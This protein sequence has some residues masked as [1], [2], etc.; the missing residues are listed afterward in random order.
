M[1]QEPEVVELQESELE[2]L[3]DRAKAALAEEDFAKFGKILSAY[4]YLLQLIENKNY[5]LARLKSIIFGSKSEKTKDVFKKT[6]IGDAPFSLDQ[7]DEAQS[8]EKPKGHGRNGAKAY[9]NAEKVKVEHPSLKPKDPCP[10]CGKGKLYPDTPGSLVRITGQAPLKATEYK[11]DKLR[12]NG[13]GKLFQAPL[14]AGV[15]YTKY[16]ATAGSM[17][18]V[19][20]YGS[21]M[22]F[23]R[24]AVLE[25]N[26]GVPLPA[27]TQWEIVDESA[28]LARPAYVELIRQA[29]QGKVLHNDDTNMKILALIKA[30]KS[31]DQGSHKRKGC[32][33]T[34]IVSLHEDHTIA[35]FFTGPNH[36]GEN[37][38]KVLKER[39]A[40]LKPPIQMCDALSRNPS[41]EFETILANCVSHSRR[42][43]VEVAESFPEECK[44]LLDT[45]KEVYLN[46]TT[47]K[48]E[49]MSDDERLA[50]H[51]TN[52]QSHMDEIENWGKKL[53]DQKKIEPNSG[54]GQALTYML[55]HWQELTLFLRYPGAPLDNNI[56]ERS[57][58]KA[59]LHRKNSMFYK[60]QKGADVG[61]LFMSLI[62]TAELAKA[63]PFDYI[64]ALLQNPKQVRENPAD[65]MP[66]NYQEALARITPPIVD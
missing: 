64:T 25:Q 62:H 65:W 34:G 57:L 58:K 60:T 28:D 2:G 14:P 35:L 6:A 15:P 30:R 53:L 16:D 44:Y 42:K 29:A 11:L 37:L 47:T 21:G 32:F 5:T 10:D 50:F 27:S 8:K 40:E 43:F 63:N 48:K 4:Q 41:Q 12:C 39:A 9:V 33:T 52:S 54:L 31:S 61:D 3:L 20:K 1:K 38:D 51:Q 55:K 59:I 45:L 26:L 17:I 24:L 22:P 56:C 23:N 19:L 13:C 49:K 46:D 7:E 18:T 66:W 36:A